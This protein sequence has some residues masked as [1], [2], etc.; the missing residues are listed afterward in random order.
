MTKEGTLAVYAQIGW[1]TIGIGVAVL[2]VSRIVTRWM[3]LETLRDADVE[4]AK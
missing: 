3:H 1:I 4:E 2:L